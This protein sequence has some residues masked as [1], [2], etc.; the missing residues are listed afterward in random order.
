MQIAIPSHITIS[1]PKI[2]K[3]ILTHALVAVLSVIL[4][5][6]LMHYRHAEKHTGPVQVA[7]IDG[8]KIYFMRPN[9]EIFIMEFD[10]SRPKFAEKATFRDITYWDWNRDIRHFVKATL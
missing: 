6:S 8:Q 10:G 9:R 3:P 7:L 2:S 5:V 4:F 1:V